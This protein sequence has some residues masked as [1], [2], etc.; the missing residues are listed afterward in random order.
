MAGE[1]IL[2]VDDEKAIQTSLRGILED[3]GYRA[4]AVGSAADALARIGEDSP[5]AV[6]LDIWMEGM[7]G[8]QLL[9]QVNNVTNEPYVAYSSNKSRLLDY[10]DY[11]TQYLLGANYKF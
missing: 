2:I 3:E 5:D 10:Q 8:L 6:L 1:Q 7:D 11:G 4:S 9:F